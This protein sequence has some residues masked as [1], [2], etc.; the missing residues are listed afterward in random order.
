[1]NNMPIIYGLCMVLFSIG[2]YGVVTKRNA[3]KIIISIIIME[4]AVNLFILLLGYKTNGIAPILKQG[5]DIRNFA[6]TAVD[7]LTQ[8]MVLTSIVIG[9]S[10]VALMVAIAIR[11]YE[12]FGT[13]DISEMKDLKG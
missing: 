3:I 7:P 9:L 8:A 6:W 12:R 1:M 5:M 11:L 13:F 2:L 4:N 10:V